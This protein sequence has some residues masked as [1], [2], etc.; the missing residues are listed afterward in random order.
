MI[1]EFYRALDPV[2]VFPFRLLEPPFLGFLL[3]NLYVASICT[4]LGELTLALLFKFN[5]RHYEEQQR[6]MMRSQS[7]SIQALMQKRKEE[8]KAANKLAN[9]AFGK[10]FFA[11]IAFSSSSLWPVPFAL[12]W[13]GYR[14]GHLDFELLY[15]LPLVGDKLGCTAVFILIYILTR[16]LGTKIRKSILA[17][18]EAA[19]PLDEEQQERYY[20]WADLH[21][22]ENL[23]ESGG[24][25]A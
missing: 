23:R 3:G 24:R 18:R 15:P 12:G 20:T 2:L 5:R 1:Y 10:S 6:E 17:G 14:F 21:N 13:L 11:G 25:R 19:A 4:L 9:E 8:F 22:H 16:I 7:L